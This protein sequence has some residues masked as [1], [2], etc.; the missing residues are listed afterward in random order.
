MTSKGY[1]LAREELIRALTAYSGITTF[2]G[3]ADGTT[4]VD[5]NL[6]GRNDFITEKTIV[7]TSGDAQSEDKGAAAFNNVNG[8]IT[9]QGTGFSAQIKKG[10]TFRV[11]NISS[12]EIDVANMDAKVETNQY[13]DRIFF[14]EDTGI[15]GTAWPIGTPQVPSD[16]IA[17]VITMCVARNLHKINVHGALTLG[18]AMAHYCFFG[19]EHEDIT[20]VLNLSDEAVDGSH[21]EGLIVTGGQGGTGYLT[22]V[23]CIVNA[24]TLFQGRMNYCSF[25]SG[26]CS[27]KDVGY[28]DLVD[29]ES[30]YGVVTIEVQAPARASIKNWRGNL[31]L[32][33]Q[34]GGL[35]FVRGIKGTLEIDAMT[36]GTLSVYANGADITINA[37][38]SGGTINIYGNARVTGAGGGVTINNY[39]LDTDLGTIDTVVDSIK[40]QTDKLAGATPGVGSATENWN[41][42][43]ADIVSIGANDT[44]NKLHSLLVN[45]SAMTATA[46]I[47]IRMYTQIN[48]TER[49]VYDQD[50]VKDTDPDGLWIVNGTVGI[51]EVLRVT[52]QSDNAGDDGKTIDYDYMLEVM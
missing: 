35:L 15:A 49:K 39:T 43:E 48:G 28:I 9:L 7:I 26:T 44:K 1:A 22:L 17:D 3:A 38:C 40:A 19:S 11:L 25:W 4:L 42:A 50:F 31:I 24:L 18:A 32:T 36:A 14:D 46:T 37:D 51:H 29:C 41:A 16:V 8:N 5:S 10:T 23:R 27:F 6:I 20:D 30:I 47:T 12:I 34:D 2:D 52:A 21:I 45:I 13:Y 33:A